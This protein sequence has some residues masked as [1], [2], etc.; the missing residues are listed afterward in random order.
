MTS[1]SRWTPIVV[2]ATAALVTAGLGGLLTDL[3]PWYRALKQPAWKPPDWAFGPI[4]TTILALWAVAGAI[5]WRRARSRAERAGLVGLFALNAALNLLWSVL[6]FHLRRPD[7]ALV[8]VPFLWLSVLALVLFL[9]RRSKPVSALL[10]PY[11]VWVA[12]AA[13]LNWKGVQLNGP[14]GSA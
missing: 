6:Y 5:G 2:A 1:A 13:A 14:F 11:L 10:L 7:W 3:G 12:I 9:A 4:W 8:E